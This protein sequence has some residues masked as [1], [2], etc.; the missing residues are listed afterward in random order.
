MNNSSLSLWIPGCTC[1]PKRSQPSLQCK[2]QAPR[3]DRGPK[4]R[5][6]PQPRM[7]TAAAPTPAPEH[8][9]SHA[10][11]ARLEAC[12]GGS[13]GP[14]PWLL[15]W[16]LATLFMHRIPDSLTS[17]FPRAFSPP[18]PLS[19]PDPHFLT[20]QLS[21]MLGPQ[22]LPMPKNPGTFSSP[23]LRRVSSCPRPLALVGVG[24]SWRVER[25]ARG[26][27]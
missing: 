4:E 12:Q 1:G 5:K 3:A 23:V 7:C 6:L 8:T 16:A 9:R 22:F 21:G 19:D 26:K 24:R 25:G 27:V 11:R 20:P 2:P 18:K 15:Y 17:C 13:P 14:G 10:P